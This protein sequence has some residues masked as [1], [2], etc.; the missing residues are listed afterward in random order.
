MDRRIKCVGPDHWF[1]PSA[2]ESG[3]SGLNSTTA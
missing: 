3:K 2:R 1:R